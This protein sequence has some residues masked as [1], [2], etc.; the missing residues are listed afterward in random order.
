MSAVQKQ[1]QE[2]I[3]QLVES[4]TERGVQAAAYQNGELMV[5][6]V[7]G[8]ADSSTGRAGTSGT[9]F[10]TFSLVKGAT[11]TVAHILAERGL[12]E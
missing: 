10:Y 12:Y 9:P 2:A 11:S 3:D 5:D 4:G 1:V 6:A 7:A 8:V